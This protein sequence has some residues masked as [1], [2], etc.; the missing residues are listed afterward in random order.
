MFYLLR[1]DEVI[2]VPKLD[3]SAFQKSDSHCPSWS[4]T[5]LLPSGSQQLVILG[6]FVQFS[7]MIPP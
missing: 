3:L 5:L 2:P 7:Q 6:C 4:V 1:E